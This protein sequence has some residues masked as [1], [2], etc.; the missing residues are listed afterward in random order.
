[1]NK[2]ILNCQRPLWEGDQEVVK[3]CGRDET[4]WVS[5]HKCMEAMLGISLYSYLY[6]KLAK[7][8]SF[9]LS[10]I[11][12]LQQNWRRRGQNRFC[13]EAVG[14]EEWKR[15]ERWEEV[16]QTMC[17]HLSKCKNDKIKERKKKKRKLLFGANQANP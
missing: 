8:L 2:I 1:V 6:L 14:G 4:M 11:F 5:M 7:M 12:S 16:A 10:L 15:W 9:L 3:R 13:L 17:T